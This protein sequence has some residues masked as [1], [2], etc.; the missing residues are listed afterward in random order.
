MLDTTIYYRYYMVNELANGN[1]NFRQTSYQRW[2]ACSSIC[3][4]KYVHW[5]TLILC[6]HVP[7]T[8]YNLLGCYVHSFNYIKSL[9]YQGRLSNSLSLTNISLFRKRLCLSLCEH[10][11]QGGKKSNVYTNI[12]SNFYNYACNDQVCRCVSITFLRIRASNVWKRV[13]TFYTFTPTR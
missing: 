5:N 9:H 13:N 6:I 7:T 11:S 4:K 3:V 2:S 10:G 12:I 8:G 1:H